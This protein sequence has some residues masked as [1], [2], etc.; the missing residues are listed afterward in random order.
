MKNLFLNVVVTLIVVAI[1]LHYFNETESKSDFESVQT[2][3]PDYVSVLQLIANPEKYHKK[4][5]GV[6]GFVHLQF[7]G[8]VI[9]L[10][11]EDYRKGLSKNCLWISI[12][13][14]SGK[15][16]TNPINK[17]MVVEGIF[18]AKNTG[19]QGMTSGAIVKVSRFDDWIGNRNREN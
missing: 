16:N 3:E 18:D 2:N 5:V 19:H 6:I 15:N 14:M 1:C 13:N 17:Y 12:K 9:C 8:D 4:N 10:H 11:E 7:E